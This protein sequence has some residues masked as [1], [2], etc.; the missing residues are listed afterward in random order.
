MDGHMN[1]YNHIIALTY[2]QNGKEIWLPI[3]DKNGMP[4]DY[5]YGPRWVK[6]TFRVNA[7]SINDANLNKGLMDF[8]AFWL[9]K[10]GLPHHNQSFIIK[11]KK[12]KIPRIFE[13]NLFQ[14]Q[15]NNRWMNAGTLIWKNKKCSISIPKSIEAL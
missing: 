6:W 4:D 9:G 15:I 5:I 7:P 14:K 13:G 1:G 3:I 8:T 11:V 2:I 10:Q 12:I